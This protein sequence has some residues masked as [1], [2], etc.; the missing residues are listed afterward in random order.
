LKASAV[1]RTP[2][3][4]L[5]GELAGWL[6]G[7]WFFGAVLTA[8]FVWAFWHTF[9]DLW[10]VWQ[11]NADYSAGQ[12]VPLTVL[13]MVAA[14]RRRLGELELRSGPMGFMVFLVGLALNLAGAYYLYA[15]LENLGIVICANGL[16]LG[17]LGWKAYKL[18]WYPMLFLF[19]MVPLPGHIHDAVMLPLQRMGA[20][21]SAAILEVVGVPVERYGHV[22][23]VAGRRIAVAEACNGLR[24]VLAFV[25][26]AGVVAFVI[27][28]PRWQKGF[29]VVSSIPIAL[30]CNVLRVV[31]TACMY[32]AGHEQLARGAFH[33][34]MGL[35]MMPAALL[36]TLLTLILLPR[37]AA[38]ANAAGFGWST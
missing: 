37:R 21:I 33:D 9:V 16:V 30:A 32:A 19:L 23:E 22:L 11:D 15:S 28:R 27:R 13:Y 20:Q 36:L 25:I 14:R 8:C 26:V 2:N 12:L 38:P 24:M 10:R 3:R 34:G 1:Y 7:A 4:G 17:L 6:S 18:L 5:A 35:V 31:A 29:I